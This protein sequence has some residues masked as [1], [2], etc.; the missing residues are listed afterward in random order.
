[1]DTDLLLHPCGLVSSLWIGVVHPLPRKADLDCDSS[2]EDKGGDCPLCAGIPVRPGVLP[3]DLPVQCLRH[4][5]CSQSGHHL[6][7][8]LRLLPMP[9]RDHLHTC[10][11]MPAEQQ[12]VQLQSGDA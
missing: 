6:K 9:L 4:Q 5:R 8:I 10:G 2:E 1:M 7:W 3:G 11:P 12:R